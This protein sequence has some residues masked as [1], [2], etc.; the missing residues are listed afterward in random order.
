M[1][2]LAGI[3]THLAFTKSMALLLWLVVVGCLVFTRVR[4]PLI[5]TDTRALC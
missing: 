4:N 3:C 1:T 2:V 5:Y